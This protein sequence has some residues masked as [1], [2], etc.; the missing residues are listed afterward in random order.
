ML[1]GYHIF[2]WFRFAIWAQDDGK[3]FGHIGS[4]KY[5]QNLD[6]KAQRRA[7]RIQGDFRELI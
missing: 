7:D 1:M 2:G 6:R 5:P 3:Y 4:K